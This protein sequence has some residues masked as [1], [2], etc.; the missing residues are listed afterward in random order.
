MNDE[1]G[2]R[3]VT[4]L[5]TSDD[6]SSGGLLALV[7]VFDEALVDAGVVSEHATDA[8]P[9]PIV[10]DRHPRVAVGVDRDAVLV[11]GDGRRRRPGDHAQ[12]R[13]RLTDVDDLHVWTHA[14][15]QPRY[16]SVKTRR[17]D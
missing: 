7:G 16:N 13:R 10:A 12:E 11:P 17:S 15:S 14:R 9:S 2:Q 3:S 8:E 6:E 1:R 5:R 4:L